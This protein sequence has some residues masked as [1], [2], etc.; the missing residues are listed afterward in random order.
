MPNLASLPKRGKPLGNYLVALDI[1][2]EFVKALIGRVVGDEVKIIG[3]GR[4]HQELSDMQSGAIADIAAVVSNCDRAL[5]EAEQQAGFSARTAVIGIAGELVKGTTSTVRFTRKN[6]SSEINIDEMGRIIDLV[7][8]RA[9]TK[10]RQQLAWELGGK[11]V[12][13]RLVNSALVRIDIDGYKVTNP[14]GFQGKDLV[15]EMYTAFAPMIH[16]GALERTANELDLELL[17]VAAEPFAV[18]R[19]VVGD[20]PNASI[21]AILMDVGGGTTDIAVVNEGGVEGTKMF[22]IGGRAFTHAIARELDVDFPKAEAIK[23]DANSGK[24]D[25]H[26]KA[27]ADKALDKTLNVWINGV[28]LALSEFD[29]LDHLPNRILLCGGGSSLDILME[30][31]EG[32]EWRGDLPFTKKPTVQHIQP[33]EVVG[34]T[35]ATGDVSDHTFITAMGLLR[36]GMD[37][38]SSGGAGDEDTV[39]DKLNRLLKI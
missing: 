2:T 23:I 17:A 5:A 11:D 6:P 38:L 7:Q 27:A 15:V 9:E 29:K 24:L 35:D 39:K 12:E 21:S 30:R 18:A 25:G 16:I 28:E 37:T 8:E 4:V 26:R 36:V 1:G 33:N 13:V 22:G 10:A 14:V 31:L 34:I 3:V 19:S 20:D 32:S